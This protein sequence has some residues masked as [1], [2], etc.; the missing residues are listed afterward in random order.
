MKEAY[1]D[2]YDYEEDDEW[3]KR[4]D[5]I[6]AF[7]YSDDVTYSGDTYY[8][9]RTEIK[10]C[11]KEYTALT[12]RA[13]DVFKKENYRHYQVLLQGYQKVVETEAAEAAAAKKAAEEAAAK[14]AAEEAAAKKAAEEAAAK[15]AAEE[16]AA[17]KAAEEAAKKDG[18]K[19]EEPAVGD[20]VEAGDANY[21][22]GADDT[23]KYMG[24]TNKTKK[25]YTVPD[26]K[27]IGGKTRKITSIDAKAFQG[28][29]KM[30]KL[31][32]GKNVKKIAAKT[33]K[34]KKKLKKVTIKSTALTSVGNGAFNGLA[35]GAKIYMP[36]LNKKQKSKYKKLF[37]KKVIGTAKIVWK[38]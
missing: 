11:Y 16:A 20:V 36:K 1:E 29:D 9:R 28:C 13:K 19:T 14:K 25:S 3:E 31:V 22:I 27:T 26:S 30:T 4:A 38:K 15:K 24:P 18:A 6:K 21:E 12:D 5:D 10:N 32:I 33:L 34:G 35:R 37:K 17:K 2:E 7:I 23:A 8:L